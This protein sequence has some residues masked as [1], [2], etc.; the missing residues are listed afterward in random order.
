MLIVELAQRILAMR[1]ALALPSPEGSAR[2]EGMLRTAIYS[3]VKTLTRNR[4]A[5]IK[6]RARQR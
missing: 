4:N 1:Q 6:L 5:L 3:Q 2:M